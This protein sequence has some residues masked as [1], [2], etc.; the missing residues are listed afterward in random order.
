MDKSGENKDIL[1]AQGYHL[2]VAGE[3]LST[4]A[5]E[6]GLG[7][8]DAEFEEAQAKSKEASKASSKK[9]ETVQVKLDVHD[10]A[11]LEKDS[12]VPKTDDSAKFSE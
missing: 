11:T 4:L 10:I 6:G 12:S 8:N 2:L 5:R 7:I 9:N 3:D 1:D